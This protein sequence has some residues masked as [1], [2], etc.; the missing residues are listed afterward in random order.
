MKK[1]KMRWTAGLDQLGAQPSDKLV[2]LNPQ[3]RGRS[4]PVS[5]KARVAMSMGHRKPKVTLA[6]IS[7][8]GE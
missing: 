8:Q 7:I 1:G 4:N 6:K 3:F 5:V 2:D